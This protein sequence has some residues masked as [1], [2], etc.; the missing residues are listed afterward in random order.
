M[1]GEP[2]NDSVRMP[3]ALRRAVAAEV[4]PVRPL[5][6]PFRRALGVALPVLI[7]I[8]GVA[9]TRGHA[10]APFALVEWATGLVLLALALGEAVPGRSVGGN[11][12]AAALAA[13]IAVETAVALTLWRAAGG[14]IASPDALPH[15]AACFSI[16]GVLG[17]V[18]LGLG[19]WLG[20]RALPLFPVRSGL[21][22]GAAAGLFAEALWQQ[23]CARRDLVHLAGGHAAAALALTVV[24]ALAGLAAARTRRAV[25]R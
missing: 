19:T 20:G 12:A 5:P 8:A 22:A 23:V 4:G 24:G 21:L 7:A 13:G 18:P 1:N 17:L 11:R 9:L 25:A 6:P 14:S 10:P 3:E 16:E 2:W 15:A